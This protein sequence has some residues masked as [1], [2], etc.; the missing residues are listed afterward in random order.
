MRK[1]L[2]IA[3][4]NLRRVARD[5]IALFFMVVF[6]L[7]IIL[8]IGAV[9]G[10]SFT[11][12]L[13]VVSRGSGSL[14]ADLVTRLEHT[15]GVR[16][17][18]FDDR[19]SLTTAVERGQ[20]EA[21]LVIP[22]GYV[23]RIRAGDTVALPYVARQAGAASQAGLIVSAIVDAQAIELRAARFGEARTDLSFDEALTAARI[24]AA[25]GGFVTVRTTA[26]GGS[27]TSAFAYGA[28]QELVLFVFVTSL[29]AS[30]MLIESRR[31]GVAR[32]MLAS[33]TSAGTVLVGEALGRFAIALAQGLL[34]V[35]ISALLFGVDWGDPVATGAVVVLFALIGT[36][37]AMLIGSVFNTAHQ[38]GS[39]G[40][41]VGLVFAAL[42]GAMVPLEVFPPIM[43]T[44]AHATPHA[45]A[46]DAF[47]EIL[48]R[49]AGF[50]QVLPE[51]GALALYAGGVL[52]VATLLFR[53]KLS[54]A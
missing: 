16:T 51:L 46:M 24:A 40:V 35:A 47:G 50:A 17:R 7:F 30:S 6:P 20:I 41:F 32:R 14:G 52:A 39:L 54:T 26:A 25:G 15:D 13:G 42:G 8:T 44:I 4:V 18:A 49:D 1:T 22:A 45:W 12:V 48:G 9:F 19:A 38:V 33:P 28:G 29:A 27:E 34:I 5:R 43:R 11:P 31:L 36:G 53:R 3:G 37:A 23:E 21:G 10:S 2:A